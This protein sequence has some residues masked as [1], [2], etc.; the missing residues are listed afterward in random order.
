ML[1]VMIAGLFGAILLGVFAFQ[2]PNPQKTAKRR[3]EMVRERHAAGGALKANAQ[4]QIRKLMAD[5]KQGGV[6]G[7]F[8][9]LV[10]R[11]ELMRAR[12]QRTGKNI[13]LGKYAMLNAAIFVVI[14]GVLALQG[15]PIVLALLLGIL[16]GVGIPHMAIGMMI[17][18]RMA[19]FN[20]NFPDA[21][22]L[23]VRGLRS[24]LPITETLGVV[25]NEI[26]GPIADEFKVVSDRMKVG[27]TME[28]ALQEVA[29][30]LNTPE[31]QFFVITLSIQR[32]TGGNLAETLAN[33]A[34]VLRKR[35]QMK[36]KIKAMSSESK[37][38]AYIVGSLP[39][40]VFALIMMVNP[41]YMMNF[42]SDERLMI[43]GMGGLLWMSIGVAIMA[44]MVRFEI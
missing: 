21:I 2:G 26:R 30:R 42:F 3:M 31:F 20:L 4:M 19:K 38:S 6:N 1:Y 5:R 12:I 35:Q 29:N 8:S 14:A 9:T 15:A 23:M 36:L 28:A 13:D 22:E 7:V 16:A 24:G 43:A 32:E 39:F 17:N 27:T 33:L 18:K 37:A 11:P 10:P 44:K 41:D 34:D 25:A 40:I